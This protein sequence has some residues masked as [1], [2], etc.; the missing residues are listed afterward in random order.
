VRSTRSA[1]S[2]CGDVLMAVSPIAPSTAGGA[3][4]PS[5]RH[6]QLEPKLAPGLSW[7]CVGPVARCVTVARPGRRS[8]AGVAPC[9]R[10]SS[11]TTRTELSAA[12]PENRGAG[13]WLDSFTAIGTVVSGLRLE[14]R[15]TRELPSISGQMWPLFDGS[16]PG[17][18]RVRR[19]PPLTGPARPAAGR[20][21]PHNPEESPFGS[22]SQPRNSRFRARLAACRPHMP[23]TP[24]PG[25]V[26]DEQR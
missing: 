15:G 18:R 26:E 17:T 24:A 22:T 13:S 19:Q 10:D 2:R 12:W 3:G 16:S 20:T 9:C 7:V 4:A 21:N 25:G 14:N 5:G 23:W 8:G 6:H 11:A 1:G